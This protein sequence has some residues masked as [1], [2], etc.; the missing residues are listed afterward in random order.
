MICIPV[1]TDSS[2]Y[3]QSRLRWCDAIITPT[4]KAYIFIFKQMHRIGVERDP[5]RLL[6]VF[7]HSQF[8]NFCPRILQTIRHIIVQI[9]I[10]CFSLGCCD[11]MTVGCIGLQNEAILHSIEID[12]L[13]LKIQVRNRCFRDRQSRHEPFCFPYDIES[14]PEYHMHVLLSLLYHSLVHLI[15]RCLLRYR[16]IWINDRFHSFRQRFT[17]RK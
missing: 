6:T 2:Q 17:Y 5:H 10:A 1:T 9:S 12:P 14:F 7:L 15:F 11:S 13:Y 4:E 16:G 3:I 8:P